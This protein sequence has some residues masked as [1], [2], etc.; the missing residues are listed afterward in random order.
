[1][2]T[3]SV[4]PTENPAINSTLKKPAIP[5]AKWA[6]PTVYFLKPYVSPPKIPKIINTPKTINTKIVTTLIRE[7]QYSASPYKVTVNTFNKT[8]IK[9]KIMLQ[10]NGEINCIGSQNVITF[11]ATIIS[12]AETKTPTSKYSQPTAKP[13]DGSIKRVENA[14]NAPDTG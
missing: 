6:A 14:L 12:T 10:P 11:A 4:P 13:T 7:S 3:T 1:T 9:K 8:I 2:T 5:P